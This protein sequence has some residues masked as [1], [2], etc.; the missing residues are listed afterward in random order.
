MFGAIDKCLGQLINARRLGGAKRF[1]QNR[2]PSLA[3]STQG[4]SKQAN[5]N[6]LAKP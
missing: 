5:A 2:M 1:G 3:A 4:R 6:S